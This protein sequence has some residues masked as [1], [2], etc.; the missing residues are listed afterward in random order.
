MRSNINIKKGK[1]DYLFIIFLFLLVVFGLVMLASASF[2]LGKVKF[3]D[4]Y[5]YL[6]HQLIYGLSIG[7]VGFILASSI[8]YLFWG[9]ISFLLLILSIICLGLVFS[10]LGLKVKGAERWLD[11]G[12]F[13]FQPSEL[14]KLSFLVYLSSWLSQSKLRSKSFYEGFLPFLVISGIIGFLLFLQPAT[15]ITVIILLTSLV[16]YF[17]GG[18]KLRFIIGAIILFFL[19]VALLIFITPYRY[20]RFVSFLNPEVDPLGKN[21]HLNQA[22]IAIGSGGL[23]GVGYGQSTSKLNYLPE[24]IGD[25]IF[26]IIAEE[27]G[28]FGSLFLIV[29]Y[30]LFIGRIL[31]IAKNTKETFGRLLAI[32]FACLIGFQAFINIAAISGLLPLTGIPL[33]FISYGGTSLAVNL[34][35]SGIIVN[36][37]KYSR[38]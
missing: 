35:F 1:P 6:K 2:Y 20:Q 37:S 8:Y 28:F 36:I 4:S 33:P 16:V 27:L 19:V 23:K 5:Y 38:R 12:F 13:T 24:P 17:S 3:N 7:L 9:K 15:T 34:I 29:L 14:V 30:L 32:G 26:A 22:L 18:A 25:S 11:F 31:Y 21:Y 10:P